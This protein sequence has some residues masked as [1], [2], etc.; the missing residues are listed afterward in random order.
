MGTWDHFSNKPLFQRTMG[1]A[2][3]RFQLG[4]VHDTL[5]ADELPNVV[6]AWGSVAETAEPDQDPLQKALRYI[7]ETSVQYPEDN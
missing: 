1:E 5:P 6:P 4:D 7:V 3:P 2:V